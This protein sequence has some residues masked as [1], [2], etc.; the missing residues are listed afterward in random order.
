MTKRLHKKGKRMSTHVDNKT[1][2][3]NGNIISETST[4]IRLRYTYPQ[5]MKRILGANVYISIRIGMVR[6]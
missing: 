4:P 2:D 1:K 3:L 6:R 5:E